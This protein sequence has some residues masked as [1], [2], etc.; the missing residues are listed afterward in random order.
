MW[1][2]TVFCVAMYLLNPGLA[3]VWMFRPGMPPA[4]L[5]LLRQ[6]VPWLESSIPAL[7]HFSVEMW[8]LSPTRSD[9]GLFRAV[10][11]VDFA[12]LLISTAT[13]PIAVAECL[14]LSLE[15]KK[16]LGSLFKS[17]PPHDLLR[18]AGC[19]V[20]TWALYDGRGYL[21]VAKLSPPAV[22]QGIVLAICFSGAIL[23]MPVTTIFLCIRKYSWEARAAP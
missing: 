20:L 16:F 18:I 8:R 13:V 10:Y 3:I 7:N 15:K 4:V 5:D 11:L 19:A 14:L 12:I 23:M 21:D 6:Y 9:V 1:T 17:R 2:V 22:L